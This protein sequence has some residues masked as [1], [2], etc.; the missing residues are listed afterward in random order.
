MHRF[1]AS[2]L[3][4]LAAVGLLAASLGVS[5]VTA[6]DALTIGSPAPAIDIEHYVSDGEGFFPKVTKFEPGKVYMVEFWATWCPPCIQSMPHLASLQKQYRGEG[7]QI[8]SV[9]TEPL[10]T[11]EA[12]LERPFPDS[13]QTFA[14]ITS[15]YTLTT[16]PDESVYADYM[17]AASQDGIPAAFLVG[18]TGLIEW[19]GHPMNSDEPIAKVIDG[20]WDREEYKT[21][22]R[23]EQVVAASLR[24]INQL[25]G[26][27][28]F[29]D[30]IKVVDKTL[31]EFDGLTDE[32]SKSIASQLNNLRFNLRID[33]GDLGEDVLAYFREQ[34]AGTQG[35]P[36]ELVQFS[37]SMMN[38][39]QQGTEIGP[40]AAETI[41]ALNAQAE[42]TDSELKPLMHVLVAQFHAFAEKFTEA[43]AAQKK[44]VAA[45]QG[46]QKLRMES[47]LQE[48]QAM[49]LEAK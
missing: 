23:R 49:A 46:E 37:I 7:F 33:S 41:Q 11:V 19:I 39:M 28:N 45:S 15:S 30:A 44:A 42:T 21:Q 25:A 35:K 9:S 29:P 1:S 48:L 5:P 16:D 22:V 6:Q 18:K 43:I 47:L 17:E 36:Q 13:E 8:V 26:A 4:S 40:L 12:M 34:L 31:A 20:S 10:E 24:K 2:P 32:A 3:F 38:S 14:E 27:G